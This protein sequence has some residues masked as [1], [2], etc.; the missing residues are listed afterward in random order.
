MKQQIEEKVFA[1]SMIELYG[2][3][4]NKI[5]KYKTNLSKTPL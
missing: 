3:E 2:D 5:S 1:E 4:Y